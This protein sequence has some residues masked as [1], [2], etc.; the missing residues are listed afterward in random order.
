MAKFKL[1]EKKENKEEVFFK[2][3]EAHGRIIL[4]TCDSTGVSF[5]AGNIL[6]IEEDGKLHLW[7]GVSVVGIKTDNYGRILVEN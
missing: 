4:E 6:S 5:S 1:F 3:R 2:L 7:T